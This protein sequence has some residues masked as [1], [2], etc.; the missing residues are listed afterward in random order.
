MPGRVLLPER[1]SGLTFD[2]PLQDTAFLQVDA[3][4]MIN[5]LGVTLADGEWGLS[6][7]SIFL[8]LKLPV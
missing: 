4:F 5:L 3:Y 8:S 2:V 6:R 1:Q 7:T